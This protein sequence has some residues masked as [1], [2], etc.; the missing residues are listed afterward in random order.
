MGVDAVSAGN[1]HHDVA[2]LGFVELAADALHVAPPDVVLMRMEESELDDE[3]KAQQARCLL[4]IIMC[5]TWRVV[6]LRQ[7]RDRLAVLCSYLA[8]DLMPEESLW[9]GRQDHA[10]LRAEMAQCGR[11]EWEHTAGRVLMQKILLAK[12]WQERE[13]G[14]R[15]LLL[16][17]AFQPN[18]AMRPVLA[19]SFETIGK[20]MGLTAEN[21]RSAVSAAMQEI[22]LS[23]QH[24]MERLS[25]SK[26]TGEFWFMKRQHCRE[27]LSVA[28]KGKRNRAGKGGKG[29]PTEHAEDTGMGV[30][31]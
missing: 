3:L 21:T 13:I 8:P 6:R 10:E 15:A 24:R 27:A 1:E 12:G 25:R 2:V 16:V 5:I 7:I 14:K 20:A 26:G 23:L 17:Y 18:A 22:V 19:K 28:M 31:R 30:A 9:H 29:L 4:S 11:I